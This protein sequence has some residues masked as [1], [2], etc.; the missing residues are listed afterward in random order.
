VITN[1]PSKVNPTGEKRDESYYPVDRDPL[2][3]SAAV[4]IVP[5]AVGLGM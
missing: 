5:A 1:K 2:A 3:L 4:V